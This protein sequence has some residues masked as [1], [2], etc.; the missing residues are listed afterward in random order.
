MNIWELDMIK[1]THKSRGKAHTVYRWYW[2]N[3]SILRK[4][5]LDP[6]LTTYIK[7]EFKMD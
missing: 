3:W 1:M 6:Y 7:S 5:M 2:E 4:I